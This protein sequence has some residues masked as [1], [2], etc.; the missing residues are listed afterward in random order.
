MEGP[1]RLIGYLGANLEPS[2][3]L[4]HGKLL[5]AIRLSADP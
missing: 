2:V 3:K 4:C 1:R 5:S